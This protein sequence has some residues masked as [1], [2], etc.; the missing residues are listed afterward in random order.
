MGSRTLGRV[1]PE[2]QAMFVLCFFVANVPAAVPG[3]ML[4]RHSRVQTK[5]R[6]W[7]QWRRFCV[8]C[9]VDFIMDERETQ[10]AATSFFDSESQ[11]LWHLRFAQLHSAVAL[12]GLHTPAL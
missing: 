5:F 7:L 10:P 11:H 9:R 2:S 3:N 4:R 1:H 8:H 12:S 6:D